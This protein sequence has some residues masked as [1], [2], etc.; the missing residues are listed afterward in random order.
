MNFEKNYFLNFYQ[1]SS[2]L[3]LFDYCYHH[4][5]PMASKRSAVRSRLS[6]PGLF[7]F[8][9]GVFTNFLEFSEPSQNPCPNSDKPDH[10]LTTITLC[11]LSLLCFIVTREGCTEFFNSG[12]SDGFLN[13]QIM[14]SHIDICMANDALNRLD[15]HAQGLHLRNISMSAAMRCQHPNALNS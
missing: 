3:Q 2:N 5:E 4:G 15:V 10:N 11:L 14:L 8:K 12:F 6:P 1:N 13:M 9:S 7:L